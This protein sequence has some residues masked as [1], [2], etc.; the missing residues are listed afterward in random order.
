MYAP[1]SSSY[2][3]NTLFF[4]F[5]F[6]LRGGSNVGSLFYILNFYILKVVRGFFIV[7]AKCMIFVFL[8]FITTSCFSVVWCVTIQEIITFFTFSQ[9]IVTLWY[10][11][12]FFFFAFLLRRA[13]VCFLLY[14]VLPYK[15]LILFILL[16]DIK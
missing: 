1:S 2:I 11:T 13:R 15:R 10:F 14:G 4:R 12:F 16:V 9:H 5:R 3:V 6:P 7:Y 8:F